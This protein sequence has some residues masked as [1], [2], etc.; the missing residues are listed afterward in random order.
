MPAIAGG[1]GKS[2]AFCRLCRMDNLQ[3]ARRSAPSS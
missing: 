3:V 1:F 2:R